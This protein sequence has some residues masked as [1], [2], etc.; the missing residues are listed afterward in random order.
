MKIAFLSMP[1]AGHLNPMTALARRLQ[2]RGH[3]IAFIGV[4][5][6]EFFALAAVP[7]F[8]PFCEKEYP[9]GST[10]RAWGEAA[11]RHGLDVVLHTTQHLMPVLLKAALE[12]PPE[13]LAG[14]GVEALVLDTTYLFLGLVPMS[15]VMP[16]AHSGISSILICAE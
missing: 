2:S 14:T 10:S 16:Y 5:D 1:L 7:N 13:K 8:V 3:E 6:V 4:P 12:R 15:L 11:K 9:A